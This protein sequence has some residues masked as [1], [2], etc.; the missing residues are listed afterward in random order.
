MDG[1]EHGPPPPVWDIN[2]AAVY[3]GPFVNKAAHI[4]VPH[5]ATVKPCH[6]CQMQGRLPCGQCQV[7]HGRTPAGTASS[8]CRAP[9]KFTP[10]CA[11]HGEGRVGR[12]TR[13]AL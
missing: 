8:P 11:L 3:G 4:E 7:R 13:P 5:T 2:A 6:E 10:G 12:R 1:P 9:C